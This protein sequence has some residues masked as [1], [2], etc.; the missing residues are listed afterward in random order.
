MEQMW[1]NVPGGVM[2][3]RWL[4]NN[5]RRRGEERWQ[6]KNKRRQKRSLIIQRGKVETA[7]DG[8][9]RQRATGY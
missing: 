1:T 4:V 3:D 9:V 7:S 8:D 6:E 5:G 2:G